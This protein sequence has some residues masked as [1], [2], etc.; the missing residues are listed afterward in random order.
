MKYDFNEQLSFSTNECQLETDAALLSAYFPNVASV[1]K[2]DAAQDKAG[3]DYIVTLDSGATIAVDVKTRS[4]MR[5]SL[6]DKNNPPLAIETWSQSWPHGEHKN[7]P[8]W[9][10]DGRKKCDYI[11][12]KFDK[13][14]TDM[15]FV[16]PFQQ[17]RKASMNHYH[18]WMAKYKEHDQRQKAAGYISK[19]LFVPAS[20]VVNAV[21]ETFA[22]TI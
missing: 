13:T 14:D 8:G 1:K 15:V 9:T 7:V 19:C 10:F 11:M 17:L 16:L 3:I 18:E 5:I 4:K 22:A 6:K 2:T 12:Y 21:R 20:E